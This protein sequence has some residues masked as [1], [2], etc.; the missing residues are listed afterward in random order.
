MD[1]GPKTIK[2]LEES[3]CDHG[4]GKDFLNITPTHAP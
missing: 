3:F 4:V 1:Y 2:H